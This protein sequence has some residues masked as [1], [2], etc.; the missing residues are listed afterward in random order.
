M[1]KLVMIFFVIIVVAVLY[2]AIRSPVLMENITG[3]S[4]FKD[5]K[6]LQKEIHEYSGVS[7]DR[8]MSYITNMDNAMN[9]LRL[10]PTL[11]AQY[12]YAAL[13][14]LRNVG[15]NIP[16]GDSGVPHEL[17]EHAKELGKLFE[18]SIMQESLQ[19]GVR[20]NPAYLNDYF[21]TNKEQNE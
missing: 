14:D 19:Q 18:S 1:N 9:I 21:I 13:E 15:L 5:I 6:D 12:L 10:D 16:G 2:I 20:F 3:G 4:N 11:S 8:Y 17:F 7:P